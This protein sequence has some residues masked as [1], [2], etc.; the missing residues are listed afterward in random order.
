MPRSRVI[1]AATAVVPAVPAVLAPALTGEAPGDPLAHVPDP[2]RPDRRVAST[3]S[4]PP[5]ATDV[6]GRG[7]G[8]CTVATGADALLDRWESEA[9]PV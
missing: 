2:L 8:D 7:S 3:G 1:L 5:G 6:I 4:G 9:G